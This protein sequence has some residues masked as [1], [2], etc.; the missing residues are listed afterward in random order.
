MSKE[1]KQFDFAI[2]TLRREDFELIGFDGSN[3]NDETMGVLAG[4]LGEGYW[5]LM[6]EELEQLASDFNVPKLGQS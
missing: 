1:I 6:T 3:L 2:I 5:E 4:K